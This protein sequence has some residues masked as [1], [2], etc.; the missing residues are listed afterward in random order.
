MGD[1]LPTEVPTRKTPGVN[2]FTAP[3]MAS[4]SLSLCLSKSLLIY[5]SWSLSISEGV[6]EQ[7][8]LQDFQMTGTL[9]NVRL[10]KT[11]ID[12][13]SHFIKSKNIYILYIYIYIHIYI[14][15]YI[16]ILYMPYR[17]I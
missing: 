17:E 1:V 6:N 12:F 16:Y 2:S 13:P 8:G 7:Q 10:H 4:L 14:Y 15:I 5:V 3:Q 9:Q 11:L